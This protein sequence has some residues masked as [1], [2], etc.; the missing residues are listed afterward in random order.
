MVKW[1][2]SSS[3]CLLQEFLAW[4]PIPIH[5][6]ILPLLPMFCCL[7]LTAIRVF[8]LPCVCVCVLIPCISCFLHPTTKFIMNLRWFPLD[9]SFFFFLRHWSLKLTPSFTHHPCPYQLSYT[10]G[11]FTLDH[12]LRCYIRRMNTVLKFVPSKTFQVY[13]ALYCILSV[14][15]YIQFYHRVLILSIE[16]KFSFECMVI[17]FWICL[18]N[19]MVWSG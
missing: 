15:T 14:D 1:Q 19:E 12:I 16:T 9:L 7:H 6:H 11:W 2:W 13:A 5:N 8:L 4:V 17:V 10:L 18:R 3:I